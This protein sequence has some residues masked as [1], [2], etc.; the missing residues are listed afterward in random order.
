MSITP[1]GGPGTPTPS[2]AGRPPRPRLLAHADVVD[3][4]ADLP[5]W[6]HT[7]GAL[8]ARY[9]AQSVPE[10]VELV[11]QAFDVAEEMDHHPDTDVRWR[12]VRFALST[13]DR[14][15]V[16]QL[17][18]ELAHR[19]VQ[20]A[21]AVGAEQLAALADVVELGIDTTDAARLAPF[22][23]A[24]LGYRSGTDGVDDVLVDPHGRGPQ[25]WFQET[26]TPA[27]PAGVRG[28]AHVDVTVADL[29]EAARRREAVEAAGGRLLSDAHAP[30]WWVYADPD[31]N[32]LCICTL[33]GREGQEDR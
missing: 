32:E 28:R 15:G 33:F 27:S 6:A 21:A 26:P 31:G 10:A 16:T 19:L 29:D 3:Q 9:R 5:G 12:E 20:A 13:H 2:A 4:L 17:D 11:R 22:W 1:P 30:S 14:G 18:V 8:H 7:G 23:R 24:A 25:V